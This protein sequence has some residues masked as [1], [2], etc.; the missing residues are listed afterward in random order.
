MFCFGGR[1]ANMELQLPFIHRI[2][3]ENPDVEYHL[4]NLARDRQDDRWLRS[5]PPRD[6]LL[7]IHRFYGPRPWQR[8]DDIYRHYAG[9][10][11]EDTMFVKLDDDIVFLESARLSEFLTA[12]DE[13][14][15]AVVSAKVI[16]NGACTKILPELWNWYLGRTDLQPLLDV[17]LHREFAEMC[18]EFFLEHWT[19]LVDNPC[20]SIPT[21]DWLSINLIGYDWA[22][23][24]RIAGLLGK[25]S[26][27]QIA[28]RVFGRNARL[29]DEGL[30]NTLPRVIFNG[31][32]ACHLYFGPQLHR[33]GEH[34]FDSYR[35]RYAEVAG[36]YLAC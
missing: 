5:L 13:H 8:F 31:L 9:P 12:V 33:G 2:L 24:N 19:E 14:R 36:K 16:N 21:S 18:H 25:Q 34:L 4:W 6:R 11:F 27:H 30:V 7:M 29:G 1:R 17:H 15:D 10:E 3:D 26:P 28:G 20:A 23:A 22:M 32:T 35:V